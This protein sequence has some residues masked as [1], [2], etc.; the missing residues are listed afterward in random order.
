[1]GHYTGLLFL[2]IA[3]LTMIPP[4]LLA[5]GDN[6]CGIETAYIT[7]KALGSEAEFGSLVD[8]KYV[9]LPEGST[10]DNMIAALSH[11]GITAQP[12]RGLTIRDLNQWR[13]PILL[14]VAHT[15]E[16]RRRPDHWIVMRPGLNSDG[17]MRI[18]DP[19][20][21]YVELM[22]SQIQ[23]RWGGLAILP[24]AE[25]L[26]PPILLGFNLWSVSRNLVRISITVIFVVLASKILPCIT[27]HGNSKLTVL[28]SLLIYLCFAVVSSAACNSELWTPFSMVR[29]SRALKHDMIDRFAEIIDV[30][31]LV[32]RM[33]DPDWRGVI[34][35][36]R[37][38]EDYNSGHIIN[39][40][41][42]P[43]DQAETA[44]R[45]AHKQLDS[46][47]EIVIYCQS[48]SCDYDSRVARIIAQDHGERQI[49]LFTQGWMAWIEAN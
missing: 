38:Q 5:F 44:V 22:A 31:S 20:R 19:G 4:P 47:E 36:A 14:L 7:A 41:N 37:I 42:I 40:I 43:V 12:F 23:A 2:A 39:A 17:K 25:G 27:Q 9:S 48:A 15:G 49:A 29:N 34:V 11:M 35:D 10:T 1:M 21:G 8:D 24:A 32:E 26:Q 46:A 13:T 30:E 45:A 18:Y 28:R 16:S 6:Y 33:K 3:G